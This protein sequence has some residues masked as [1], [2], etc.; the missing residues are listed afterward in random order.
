LNESD[1]NGVRFV[2]ITESWSSEMKNIGMVT[3]GLFTDFNND[4]LVDL[5][6]VGEWMPICLFMNTGS[7]F[8]L[9][10]DSAGLQYS[11]GWWNSIQGGDFDKDGDMDYL[12]G[13]LGLNSWLK[14]TR[15]EP[16]SMYAD[17]YDQDGKI[18]PL[19][20][21]FVHG[22]NVPFHSRDL[23]VNQLSFLRRKF[24][25]YADFAKADLNDILDEVQRKQ[26]LE[27]FA[28]E[29]RSS[30]IENLGNNRFKMRPLDI[31]VQVSP[32]FGILIDDFDDDGFFDAI[33]AGN[34]KASNLTLG[35]Y[36]ASIGYFLK[37]KGDGTFEIKDGTRSGFYVDTDAKGIVQL[38]G[39]NSEPV[40][41]V[42]NNDDSLSVFNRVSVPSHTLELPPG[43]SSGRLIYKDGSSQKIEF[44]NGGGY[45]SGQGRT[46]FLGRHV[47]S[48]LVYDPSNRLLQEVSFD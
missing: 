8:T 40:I 24:P 21:H 43:G 11:H 20:F 22:K 35:W 27:F 44:Y 41:V 10:S 7:S 42:A 28:Y 31:S 33:M 1:K 32:M 48:I 25:T 29:L 19:L 46:L 30:Y 14:A 16:I 37:G 23:L 38:G 12:A 39:I 4:Q 2:D 18:D 34:S 6:L 45:L 47:K 5:I 15:D 3:G 26:S 9:L 17:D 36:D 13:N